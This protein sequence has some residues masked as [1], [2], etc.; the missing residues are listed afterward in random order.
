[1]EVKDKP[2]TDLP[3]P[4][5]VYFFLLLGCLQ[6]LGE[7]ETW[8]THGNFPLSEK[9]QNLCNRHQVVIQA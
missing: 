2:K 5:V 4:I 3:F 6:L 7:G 1:M 8:L 9:A